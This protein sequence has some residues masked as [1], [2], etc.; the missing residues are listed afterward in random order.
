MEGPEEQMPEGPQCV[1]A[2]SAVFCEVRQ[3]LAIQVTQQT[4][5]GI[6]EQVTQRIRVTNGV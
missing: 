1:L 4:D 5:A 6:L 3:P 2:A